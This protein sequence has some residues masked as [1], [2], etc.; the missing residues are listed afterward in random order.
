MVSHWLEI[1]REERRLKFE[2]E[3]ELRNRLT[4]GLPTR[5]PEVI[6]AERYE[7]IRQVLHSFVRQFDAEIAIMQKAAEERKAITETQE[8]A[9]LPEPS[10]H[11]TQE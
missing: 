5:Y 2:A 4:E 1:R 3:R 10:D 7:V 8:Q 11:D 6:D 9:K